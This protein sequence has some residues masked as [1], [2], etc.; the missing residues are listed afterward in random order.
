VE[1]RANGLVAPPQ[2]EVLAAAIDRLFA[3][4][5][6]RLREMGENGRLR[7]AHVSWDVVVERLTE[8]VR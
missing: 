4:P 1:D 8:T 7:V 2:P 6:G 5:E 3:L